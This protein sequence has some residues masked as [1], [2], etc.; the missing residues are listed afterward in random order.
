[1][2]GRKAALCRLTLTSQ[3]PM[4]H[5]HKTPH[6]YIKRAENRICVCHKMPRPLT[7]IPDA[8]R[9]SSGSSPSRIP[10]SRRQPRF[11]SLFR[12]SRANMNEEGQDMNTGNSLSLSQERDLSPLSRRFLE[13]HA[14]PSSV[15]QRL[16]N[17]MFGRMTPL[18]QALGS[19]IVKC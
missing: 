3:T 5:R 7:P 15:D 17:Y 19:N 10:I 9:V 8:D 14:M 13:Q 2:G 11:P 1:M 6:W 18:L 4:T 16:P 12:G